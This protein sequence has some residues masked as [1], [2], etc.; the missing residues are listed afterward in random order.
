MDHDKDSMPVF[1]IYKFAKKK[2]EKRMVTI[3][4]GSTLLIVQILMCYHINMANK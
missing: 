3:K 2:L 1:C 4:Y